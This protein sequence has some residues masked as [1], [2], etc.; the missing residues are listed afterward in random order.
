MVECSNCHSRFRKDDI[1]LNK[2]PN[3]GKENSFGKSRQFNLMFK[4]NIGPVE[5]EAHASYL[6][7]ETAQGIFT[8]FKNVVDSFQPDMPFGIAQVG[9][10]FR[11]EISP[12]DFIFR[13]REMEMMEIEYFIHPKDDWQKL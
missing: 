6:R 5:D 9:K 10:A 11:N 1:D 2:C 12:R 7:P 4:T 3:C 13:D 8:N